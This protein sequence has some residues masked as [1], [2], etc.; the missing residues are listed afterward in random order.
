MRT[1]AA[2]LRAGLTRV[3][4]LNLREIVTHRL[5]VVT[6]LSVIVVASALLVAVFGTF[7]SLTG[8]V[9]DMTAALTG[10]ADLEVA[11][12]SDTGLDGRIAGQLRA[13]LDDA[14][15]VVP[16]IRA[17]VRLDPADAEPATDPRLSLL[18]GSDQ[19]V[20]QLS[21]QLRDALRQSEG[22]EVDL[23]ALRTGVIAGPGTGLRQGDRI[24]I[25]GVDVTV[26]QVA[27]AAGTE[28]LNR[29]NFFFAF[30][31]LAQQITARAGGGSAESGAGRVDSLL[32]VAKPGADLSQMRERAERTVDGRAVVVD[33][34]FRMKQAEV[35]TA[36]TRDSTLLVS[37]ISLVI[38][39]FLVFNTMNMAVA[40]RR[41]ALAMVR[42]LGARRGQLVSDMLWEAAI[43]GLVGG[44]IGIPIGIL[45]GRWAIGRLPEMTLNSI[46]AAV[47]YHLPVF[48]PFVA[49]AAC[50]LACVAATALAARTV[51]SVA[52]VEAM[53]AAGGDVD[54]PLS[55]PIVL[56]A[57]IGG[58]GGIVASWVLATTV[59][60]RAAIVAGAV[61]GACGLLLCFALTGPLVRAATAVAG[62]FGPPGT[63]AAV[64]TERASRRVWA[65]VMTVA[66]A[67][68]VGMG[69]SGA[70]QNLV[71]SISGSLQGLG[72][73][74]FY[75]STSNK[76]GIPTGPTFGDDVARAAAEVPGVA[77]VRDSQWARVNVGD[78]RI[79]V[80]GLAPGLKAPFVVKTDPGALQR[81]F[82]G[83]GIV[84]SSVLSRN[85]GLGIGDEVRMATPTGFHSLTVRDVVDY[86][87]ID[88]GS[89]AISL[90][91]L[92]EW[93]ERPGATFLQVD[94][95]PGAD[96]EQVR[97]GLEAVAQRYSQGRLPLYVYSGEEALRATQESAEQ[98]GAFTVAIQWIVAVAAAVALLNTLLL[99]VIERRRELAVLRA[100]GASRRFVFSMV[101]SEA[102]AIAV[103][104]SITGLILGGMLH[105]LSDQILTAST[106]IQVHYSP[107]WSTLL[108][109]AVSVGLCIVGALTPA[110]RAARLNISESIAAE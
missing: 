33:P 50:V 40:S 104:G 28:V 53:S 56:I 26:L 107:Q 80:Q 19:R 51:F 5:R 3:R 85:L 43:F 73:P 65:T 37:V 6:S 90:D 39:G 60:G 58:I 102:V 109:V 15:A 92:R 13:D 17:Q 68:A 77:D 84:L 100:L 12:I 48:A 4:L 81:V 8:S 30:L 78:A 99:S 94:T 96:V 82:D 67:I 59:P 23:D 76:D 63:L 55:R 86:V 42:A 32:I 70:L 11:G 25:N 101:L 9:R 108:Y 95:E 71:S 105:L 1:A 49:L 47:D 103:V 44:L 54:K 93:F 74:G 89:A 14:Q 72:D 16:M 31:P 34:A 97:A 38:A 36:V 21:P 66:V 98:S 29:G 64:N 52:P 57:G 79:L 27:P 91:L 18:I 22:Q 62:R 7:G 10:E 106:S 45:A 24:K 88:S 46:G 61:F 83:D 87:A 20:T 110:V 69:T 75:L 35:A 41:S 2:R